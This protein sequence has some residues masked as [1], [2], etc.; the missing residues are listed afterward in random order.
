M[1]RKK[2]TGEGSM[3]IA[4]ECGLSRQRV[5]VLLRRGMSRAEI[6]AHAKRGGRLIPGLPG[7]RP[8][9]VASAKLEPATS[10]GGSLSQQLAEVLRRKQV[11]R[12]DLSELDEQLA[13]GLWISKPRT[14]A[15]VDAY[16]INFRDTLMATSLELG[17]QIAGMSDPAAI[18]ELLDADS[19]RALQ[20][21]AELTDEL[22]TDIYDAEAR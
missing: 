7:H 10:P 1:T 21:L 18:R 22:E 20:Y 2:P 13:A 19:R 9:N 12:A 3:A 6:L 17:D 8:G 14:K 4:R 16:I 11:A 15:I 5:A